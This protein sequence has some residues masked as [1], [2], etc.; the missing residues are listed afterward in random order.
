VDLHYSL[1]SKRQNKTAR[2]NNNT[3][4]SVKINKLTLLL[5]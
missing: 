5:S 2:F 4:F 3:I 1:N